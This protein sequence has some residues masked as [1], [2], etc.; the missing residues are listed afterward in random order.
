MSEG[1]EPRP[2]SQTPTPGTTVAGSVC[3]PADQPVHHPLRHPTV[4][5]GGPCPQP[6]SR[7]GFAVGPAGDTLAPA[8]AQV[9]SGQAGTISV[10]AA[11]PQPLP[12]LAATD[13]AMS[14]RTSRGPREAVSQGVGSESMR[15]RRSP[16]RAQSAAVGLW[17]AQG[18]RLAQPDLAPS[19]GSG[20]QP[21]SARRSSAVMRASTSSERLGRHGEAWRANPRCRGWW[22]PCLRSMS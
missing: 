6:P 14:L 1:D 2:P 17:R 13:R 20:D 15:R 4:P 19:G 3:R 5:R 18:G 10:C 7:A 21:F 12:P 22:P 9:R 16:G 11:D 8:L